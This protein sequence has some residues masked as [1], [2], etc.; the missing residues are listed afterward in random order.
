MRWN[1]TVFGG[2]GSD[3]IVFMSSAISGVLVFGNQ[4]ADSI[5]GTD[6][7]DTI[8]GGSDFSP[9]GGSRDGSDLLLGVGGNDVVLGGDGADSIFGGLGADSMAGGLGADTFAIAPTEDG[10][11][12]NGVS[13][14]DFIADIN[15]DVDRIDVA[16]VPTIIGNIQTVN[17]SSLNSAASQVDNNVGP[18]RAC[19]FIYDGETYLYENNVPDYS[20]GDLFIRVTGY[21]GTLTMGSFV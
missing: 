21:T 16:V 6:V 3:A 14:L 5:Q 13:G 7:G 11:P 9:T 15:F 8:C 17:A 12:N 4:G 2:F 19:L 20:E 1:S 18:G 10:S